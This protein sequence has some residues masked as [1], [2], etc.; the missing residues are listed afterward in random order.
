M[1][2]CQNKYKKESDMHSDYH[3]GDCCLCFHWRIRDTEKFDQLY[4]VE[5]WKQK[6]YL[7][8]SDPQREYGKSVHWEELRRC[9]R[10][11]GWDADLTFGDPDNRYFPHCFLRGALPDIFQKERRIKHKKA[12]NIFQTGLRT[13]LILL[14]AYDQNAVSSWTVYQLLFFRKLEILFQDR[15]GV[16]RTGGICYR[17]AGIYQVRKK[18]S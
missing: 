12:D 5:Q 18:L 9:S 8:W 13:S 15:C 6:C 4:P 1:P 2:R 3:T 14:R 7:F 11:H 17:L 10:K 16:Y